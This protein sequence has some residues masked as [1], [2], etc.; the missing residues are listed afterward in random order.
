MH[1]WDKLFKNG[2]SKI[3]GRQPLKNLKE[4]SLLKQGD[5]QKIVYVL[6]SNDR[7]NFDNFRELIQN[8][9]PYTTDFF[10]ENCT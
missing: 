4:Y 1:I 9:L 6:A 7:S 8:L 10:Q 3:C 2:P 5:L